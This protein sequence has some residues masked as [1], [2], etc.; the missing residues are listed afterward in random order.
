MKGRVLAEAITSLTSVAA[1]AELR[2]RLDAHPAASAP[3]PSTGP[4]IL[5]E[6]ALHG[7]AGDVI[8][9]IDP[10]TEADQA[11]VFSNLLV[12]FGSAVGRTPHTRVGDTRHGINLDVVHVG[13]SSKG[14]KGTA[15]ATPRRLMGAVDPSWDPEHVVTGLSSGE[16]LIWAVRDPIDKSEPIK[17]GK[18]ISGYQTVMMDPGVKD[19]RLLVIEEE[20]ASVLQRARRE[21]NTLSAVL[22]QAWD[23]HDLRVLTKNMPAVATAP[24]V[25]IVGHITREE[26][27]RNLDSTE[28]ANGF[29]NRFL[30]VWVKRSKRLPEGGRVPEDQIA[31]LTTRLREALQF[32]QRTGELRRDDKAK[33]L[34][35]EVY[36]ELSEPRPGLVG[37]VTARGEAQ[38]LR[39]SSLYALLDESTV[40]RPEHLVAAL[41]FWHYCDGSARFV[42]GDVIGDPIAD[43]IL[44]ALRMGGPMTQD[45]IGNLFGH[46]VPAAKIGRALE[47]LLAA[48]LVTRSTQ[49][50]DGGRGRPVTLWGA[51]S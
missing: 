46:N 40:I 35:A 51:A 9:A 38:V 15:L 1:I 44:T 45:G 41:A 31:A 36:E 7:L 4:P 47:M 37:A 19:K 2:Q 3:S 25:S 22:R 48:R 49:A 27:L 32:A 28:A 50:P 34:W 14:R 16:G 18:H 26:L 20:F 5:S 29:A 21:G 8:R 33:A 24:H 43:R 42:F 17:D 10:H 30:W 12:M 6:L 39:L 13:E 11:A 23:G